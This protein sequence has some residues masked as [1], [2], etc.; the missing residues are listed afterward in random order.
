MSNDV[1]AVAGAVREICETPDR[2]DGLVFDSESVEA[3]VIK[4]DS[5]YEGVRVTFLGH[6]QNARVH[7]QIDM[8]FGDVVVPDPVPVLYPTILDHDPPQIKKYPPE[9]T[10]AEKLETMVKLGQINSRIRDFF[11]VWTLSRQFQ[12]DGLTLARAI[13]KTFANRGTAINTHPAAFKSEFASDPTKQLQW[14][15]FCRKSRI[16]FA[17]NS[18]KN[19]CVAISEFLTPVVGAIYADEQF[20]QVWIPPGPW[21]R[22]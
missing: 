1:G 10:I 9:T 12:F 19:V 5:D 16:E 22:S 13:R 15:G 8:G 17:P 6:L 20:N 4:E 3:N 11:D 14:S 21:R 7:M 18:L 2:T